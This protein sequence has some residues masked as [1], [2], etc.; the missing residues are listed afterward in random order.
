MAKTL[1]KWVQILKSVCWRRHSLQSSLKKTCLEHELESDSD[2]LGWG[3][4]RVSCGGVVNRIF[5]LIDQGFE[6][7][8][9]VVRIAESLVIVLEHKGGNVS[10]YRIKMAQ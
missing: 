10:V 6:R 9:S 4:G 3:V 1:L 2:D 7:L 5:D 8:I